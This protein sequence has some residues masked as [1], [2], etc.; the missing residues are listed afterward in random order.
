MPPACLKEMSNCGAPPADI[1]GYQN[2]SRKAGLVLSHRIWNREDWLQL[3]FPINL[4]TSASRHE[5][6]R[7]GVCVVLSGILRPVGSRVIVAISGGTLFMIRD[8]YD[9]LVSVSK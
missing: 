9:G 1:A 7:Q 2:N 8:W 6:P 4:C 3:T 5:R